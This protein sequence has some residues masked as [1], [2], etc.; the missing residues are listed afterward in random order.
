MPEFRLIQQ[1]VEREAAPQGITGEDAGTVV[2]Q[3]RD[4]V[5][6]P[7]GETGE[8]AGFRMVAAD[9]PEMPGPGGHSGRQ[10]GVP[11]RGQAEIAVEGV[12]HLRFGI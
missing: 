6:E 7:C 3:G 11:V 5:V 10:G 8:G 9:F 2:S 12:D 1:D 4:L